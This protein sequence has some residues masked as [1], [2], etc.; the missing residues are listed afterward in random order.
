VVGDTVN[1]A[2]RLEGQTKRLGWAVVASEATV[3][4]TRSVISVGSQK[5]VQLRG[6][7]PPSRSMKS[8]ASRPAT[9]TT[10]RCNPEEMRQALAENARIAGEAAKAALGITLSIMTGDLNEK[11]LSVQ[12]YP[13][14][15]EN[16]SRRLLGGVSRRAGKR[17]AAGRAEDSRRNRRTRRDIAAAFRAGVRHHL[18]DRSTRTW[19]RSTTAASA[20][21]M[22]TSRWSIFP[23]AAWSSPPPGLKTRGKPVAARSRRERAARVH[24]RGIIH[25]DIKPGNLMARAD[26]SIVLAISASRSGWTTTWP[27]APRRAVRDALLRVAGADRGQRGDRPVDIYSLGIIFHEM[28]T[29]QRPFEA[30]SVSGLIALHV[31]APRPKLPEALAEFQPLLDRMLAVDPR[32]R[33][34]NAQELLEGID[35][36]WTHQAL[37]TLKQTS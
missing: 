13:R 29:G 20:T 15:L 16:R 19:S 28:L 25:R 14:R 24:S 1:I 18:L 26:G 11:L 32:A 12:G 17:P 8:S 3:D 6:A 21:A 7:A 33:Y 10:F 37:R 4:L 22:R 35:Q 31:S 2:S 36:A 27:H 23:T 30:D 9:P 34:K 5:E